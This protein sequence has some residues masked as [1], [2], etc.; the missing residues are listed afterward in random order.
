VTDNIADPFLL[1]KA[2][3]HNNAGPHALRP[4]RLRVSFVAAWI[5]PQ[6]R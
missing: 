2:R 5:G 1:L 3:S 4:Q 6:Q